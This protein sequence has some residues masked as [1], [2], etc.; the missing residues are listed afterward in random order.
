M[1][2]TIIAM[3]DVWSHESDRLPLR[4]QGEL[5]CSYALHRTAKLSGCGSKTAAELVR[6][7]RGEEVVSYLDGLGTGTFA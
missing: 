6:Q 4:G 2:L 3:H 1:V 7:D 5:I